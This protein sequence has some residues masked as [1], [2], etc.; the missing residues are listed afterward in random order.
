MVSLIPDAEG[1]GNVHAQ[2][3]GTFG[4]YSGFF[5]FPQLLPVWMKWIYYILPFKYS[6]EGLEVNQFTCMTN[7]DNKYFFTIDP[8][9]DRWTNLIVFMVY[10]PIFHAIAVLASFLHTRPA[11]FWADMCSCCKRTQAEA[12]DDEPTSG[13]FSPV[14]SR[15]SHTAS[16]PQSAGKTSDQPV[17]NSAEAHADAVT[18][19]LAPLSNATAPN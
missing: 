10:P 4:L 16:S 9:L 17:N 14:P 18:I 19:E 6:F 13:A 3:L 15:A 2:I 5:L 12:A 8:T 11:S 1:A 7:G